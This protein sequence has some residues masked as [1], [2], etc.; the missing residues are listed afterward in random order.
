MTESPAGTWTSAPIEL[1]AGAEF[2]VRQGHDWTHN[3]GEGGVADGPNMTVSEDGT[4]VVV[5][6]FDEASGTATSLTV[7]KQ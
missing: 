4:Y 7:T 5:L 3:F 2:K 1:K 6:V